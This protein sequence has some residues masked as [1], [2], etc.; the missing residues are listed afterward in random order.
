LA[1]KLMNRPILPMNK[2]TLNNDR[3]IPIVLTRVVMTNSA[4]FVRQ[5][6]KNAPPN[7]PAIPPI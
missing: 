5:E 1:A 2:F 7:T 6:L 4:F 3:T